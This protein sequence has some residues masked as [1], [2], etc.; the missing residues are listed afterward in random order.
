MKDT[1][2]VG[3]AVCLTT[4]PKFLDGSA[5]ASLF[6]ISNA[7]TQARDFIIANN[8]TWSSNEEARLKG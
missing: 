8:A 5:N 6:G 2:R 3:R 4:A 7:K 1:R